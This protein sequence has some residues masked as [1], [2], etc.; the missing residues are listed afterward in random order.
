MYA[1]YGAQCFFCQLIPHIHARWLW[2]V[3]L[4][5]PWLASG[6]KPLGEKPSRSTAAIAAAARFAQLVAQNS[7]PNS[8][9]KKVGDVWAGS[10]SGVWL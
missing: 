2:P 3:P 4:A 5:N 1:H 6:H 10:S 8:D 7:Q 9:R